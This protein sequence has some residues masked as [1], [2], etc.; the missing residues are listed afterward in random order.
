MHIV[1][2]GASGLLG[3]KLRTELEA[4]GHRVTRLVRRPPNS[5]QQAEW[6]P[7]RGELD[8][9][10]LRR[11]DA[12]VG[13]SGAGVGDKRWTDSYKKTLVESR[14]DPTSL[15]AATIASL[16]A[17]GDGPATFVSASAVGYYGDTGDTLTTENGPKGKGFLAGLVERWEG[18]T[19]QAS[20]AGARVATLR[21]GLVLAPSGGLMG[22]IAP[23]AKLGLA[24]PL[25]NGR[26]YWP[27]ITLV[28]EIDAI[29]FVLENDD[30]SGPVNLTGP[31]PVTNREFATVT[32]R[33]LRR[34][35]VI[36]VPAFALRLVLGEFA[37]EGVLTGQRAV[38]EKL[39]AAGFVFTHTDVESALR[40]TF[41]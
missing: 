12:V 5:E 39:A 32:G 25:G 2:A 13:L 10:V 16:R 24:G 37:D 29:R 33:V 28:D 19:T 15:L 3:T 31:R 41:S 22:R 36:P 40:Y 38:P 7:E 6:H 27:W 18:A 4:A 9:E 14:L 1:L 20:D 34:P 17:E 35:E 21:T 8:P 23:L 11:A 30:L 26:Q